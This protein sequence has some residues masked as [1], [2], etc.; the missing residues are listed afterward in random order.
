MEVASDGQPFTAD[1]V[2]IHIGYHRSR[3]QRT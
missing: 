2:L 3:P 1:D